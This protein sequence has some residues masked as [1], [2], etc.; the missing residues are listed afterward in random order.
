MNIFFLD[1]DPIL[2]AQYQVDRHVVKMCLETAQ[3]LSTAHVVLDNNQVGYKPTH[4]NH[5]CAKWVRSSVCHY[6]WTY[7]HF[8]GLLNEYHYRY[9]KVHGCEKLVEVLASE[10][11]GT[12]VAGWS[13]PP[14]A[15]PPERKDACPVASYRSYY[16]VDKAAL[17]SWKRRDRPSWL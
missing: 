9:D 5:P 8:L 1:R 2:A 16:R 14:L 13:D 15:M 7:K 10:P 11:L 4:V 17:H 3:L 12:P 6:R